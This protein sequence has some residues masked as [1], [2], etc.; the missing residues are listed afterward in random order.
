MTIKFQFKINSIAAIVAFLVFITICLA[1][2]Q[3]EAFFACGRDWSRE[4][5]RESSIIVPL[6]PLSKRARFVICVIPMVWSLVTAD[7]G[8]WLTKQQQLMSVYSILQH[9]ISKGGEWSSLPHHVHQYTWSLSYWWSK[10][11]IQ[12]ILVISVSNSLNAGDSISDW[13]FDPQSF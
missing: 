3:H 7:G 10:Q 1:F 2:L 9:S 4:R 13:V 5:E 8:F 12:Y 6:V 11:G